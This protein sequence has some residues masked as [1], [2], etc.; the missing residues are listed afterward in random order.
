VEEWLDVSDQ[1]LHVYRFVI[2][3]RSGAAQA[4]VPAQNPQWSYVLN[5]A[6]AANFVLPLTHELCTEVILS[7]GQRQLLI[8]RD[9]SLKWGG[10]LETAQP[11][12]DGDVRF[13]A[14][15]WFE[16]LKHRL[17]TD[18]K[19]YTTTDQHDIAWDLINYSQTKTNGALGITRGGEADSGVNRDVTYPFWERANIGD[20]ILAMSELN[21]GFDFEISADKVFHMYYPRKSTNFGI[22]FELGKNIGG[23]SIMYDASDMVNHFSAIGAGDGKNTCIATAADTTSQA[24]FG[25]REAAESFTDIKR[26]ARLQDRATEELKVLKK[27]RVQPTLGARTEDPQPYSYVVGD[28]ITI[29]AQRGYMNIDRQFRIIALSYALSNEGRESITIQFDEETT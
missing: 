4:E 10:W 7:P 26:F 6:G 14:V 21:N 17:V 27:I 29:R 28:N 18:T 24:N 25:L 13:G 5:D 15:G 3:D 2:A 8:Y 19:T 23:L 11:T 1:S 20:E 9:G 22:P 12:L 16:M